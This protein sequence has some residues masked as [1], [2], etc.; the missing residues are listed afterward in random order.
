MRTHQVASQALQLRH[1]VRV[2]SIPTRRQLRNQAFELLQQRVHVGGLEL[3]HRIHKLRNKRLPFGSVIPLSPLRRGGHVGQERGGGGVAQ[4]LAQRG[5][6]MS[7]PRSG[8][9]GAEHLYPYHPCPVACRGGGQSRHQ[10]LHHLAGGGGGG[11][12]QR[13]QLLARVLEHGRGERAARRQQ[14]RLPPRRRHGQVRERLLAEVHEQGGAH[15]AT[16]RRH[17]EV[18]RRE[19]RAH[20]LQHGVPQSHCGRALQQHLPLEVLQAVHGAG[21]TEHGGSQSCRRVRREDGLQE[22]DGGG[23]SQK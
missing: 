11:Q 19:V 16:Q 23:K 10:A 13:P 17:A 20:R 15:G 6:A 1:K 18:V 7:D 5:G 4:Q 8:G 14:R 3:L 21:E 22:V 12:L 9:G 2:T